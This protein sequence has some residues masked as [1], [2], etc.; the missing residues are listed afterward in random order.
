MAEPRSLRRDGFDDTRVGVA[1]EVAPEP[2]REIDHAIPVDVRDDRA[3]SMVDDGVHMQIDGVADHPLL[4]LDERTRPRA[5]KF[6]THLDG[7]HV[8]S[9]VSETSSTQA[10]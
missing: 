7:G 5:W 3:L 2:A 1:D 8:P 9:W 6:G 4:T 10:T